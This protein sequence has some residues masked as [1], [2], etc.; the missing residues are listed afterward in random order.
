MQ[1]VQN[2]SDVDW[3]AKLD[4]DSNNLPDGG[5][6]IHYVAWDK[7]GNAVHGEQAGFIR[8]NVPVISSVTVGTDLNDDGDAN[9]TG[10]K[11]TYNPLAPI[12]AGTT[13]CTSRSTRQ[14]SA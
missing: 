3:W 1:L 8:N 11:T 4:T 13:C 6:E 9:D 2:G 7:A 12:T 10:E 14:R 5:V